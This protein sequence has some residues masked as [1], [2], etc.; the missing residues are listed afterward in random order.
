[1]ITKEA[2]NL[3]QFLGKNI[4]KV[5]RAGKKTGE[6]A[7]K[8][9]KPLARGVSS[10][11]KAGL[12]GL[13]RTGDF[14]YDHPKSSVLIGGTGLASYYGHKGNVKKYY[15]HQD[16]DKKIT[17]T[18]VTGNIKYNNPRIKKYYK[19]KNVYY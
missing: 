19:D 6:G 1:M 8:A 10:V 3:F 17:H 9:T 12:K 14:V 18:T 7:I 4:G 2:E 5:Y 11:G 15:A 13:K 16:P